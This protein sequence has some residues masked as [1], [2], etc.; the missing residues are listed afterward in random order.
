MR[1]DQADIDPAAA[2]PQSSACGQ[3]GSAGH[4]G[5]ATEN[6]DIAETAF[7][8]VVWS[9]LQV[10]GEGLPVD[11]MTGGRRDGLGVQVERRELNVAAVIG[12]FGS[13]QSGFAADEG[14]RMTGAYRHAQA[15]AGISVESAWA[16]EREQ[17][18]TIALSQCIG[19]ADQTGKGV[20]DL[21]GQAD[22]EESVDDQR[23]ASC[24]GNCGVEVPAR[25][26]EALVGF[27][28]IEREA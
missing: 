26:E 7:V 23:P 3:Q 6:A 8:A 12:A 15:L 19:L 21:P 2:Q 20:A 22:A 16:I 11:Q 18:A 10:A 5:G 17:R 13:E 25:G 14:E 24:F 9:R 4:A 1:V 28:S 27:G